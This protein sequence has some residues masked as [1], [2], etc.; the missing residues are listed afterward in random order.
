MIIDTNFLNQKNINSDICV[1]GSG[2]S[3]FSFIKKFL[4]LNYSISIL[5]SGNFF[6]DQKVNLLNQGQLDMFGNFPHEEYMLKSARVRM[7]GGTS[8][9]WAG[10]SGPLLKEDFEN[11]YWIPK[12]GWQINYDNLKNYYFEA[13]KILSLSKFIYDEKLFDYYPKKVT[14]D[15]L[16]NFDHSFWQFSN[17]P[18]NF[19]KK[20]EQEIKELKNINLYFNCTATNFSKGIDEKIE[21]L[22]AY[23]SKKD[24]I[25][26]KAKYFIIACGGI[27]NAAILLNSKQNIRQL[28]NN[29]NIGNYFFEHPHITLAR[30]TT[31]NLNFLKT[32][33]R[34]KLQQL[35]NIESLV[36]FSLKKTD[37]VKNHISN[38]INVISNHNLLD[39]ESAVIA[40]H[41]MA[42]RGKIVNTSKFISI[43]L[44]NIPELIKTLNFL[45]KN[46]F[47]KNKN[48]YII[49]RLE[50]QPLHDN[51]VYLSKSKNKYGNFLPQINWRLSDL[52]YKTLKINYEK[53]SK[54]FKLENI[55]KINASNF[56]ETID[57]ETKKDVFAVGHHMGTTRMSENHSNGVVDKNLKVHNIKNLFVAGSS[58]FP[59]GGFIN[60]TMTIIALSLRLGNHIN[61]LLKK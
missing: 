26:F 42:L 54:N 50:Q 25:L 17:P 59:T 55:G 60:P 23:N 15:K 28:D 9:V 36:G 45:T 40:R 52:D 37:R 2:P 34:Q 18:L 49:S 5:E 56:I 39:V 32:Y 51:K 41:I 7:V 46:T 48:F 43:F 11:K 30:G 24:K 33:K 19:K 58:I 14:I 53:I 29:N 3:S 27:E 20:F 38:C 35:N 47:V 13:Q 22:G 4:N 31:N 8:N 10:W 12:S 57:K 21:N 16:E 61:E 44:K 6:F 1:I